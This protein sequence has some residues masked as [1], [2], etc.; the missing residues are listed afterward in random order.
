MIYSKRDFGVGLVAELNKGFDVVRLSR[1][2]YATYLRHCPDL[3]A[4]LSDVMMEV[5]AMEE[6]PEFEFAEGELRDL[7]EK[8]SGAS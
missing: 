2:A 3:E 7:A 6:G 8:L 5:V 4:G 1:W